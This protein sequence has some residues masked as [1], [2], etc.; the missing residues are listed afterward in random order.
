MKSYGF[1][2][3]VR[4]ALPLF[5]RSCIAPEKKKALGP[6]PRLLEI[7]NRL[8]NEFQ[9][10][11]VQL[12]DQQPGEAEWDW[13]WYFLMQHHGAATRLLD[14]SDGALIALHFAL[15]N[16]NGDDTEGAFV[17]IPDD[18][19]QRHLFLLCDIFERLVKGRRKTDR[20]PNRQRAWDVHA[21]PTSPRLLH[22]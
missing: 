3:K 2:E 1:A 8:Y 5:G 14:W 9:R 22:G 16:K 13:D 20:C 7:E 10:C 15:R 6:I 17:Y 11:G 12:C 4:N 18:P 19:S 21:L